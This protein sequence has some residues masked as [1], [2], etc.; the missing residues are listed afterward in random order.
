MGTRCVISVEGNCKAKI[1]KHYDGYPEGTLP[2]LEKFN[3]DFTLNRGMD[4]EYKFAQLLRDSVRSEKEFKLDPSK[5]TGWG[6]IGYD[7]DC[8]QEYEYLLK[9]DGSVKC[10]KILD[11][12]VFM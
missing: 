12:T 2:W 6:I 3:K 1:Y 9:N 8:G 5:Y 10:K 4:P 7:A 11:K